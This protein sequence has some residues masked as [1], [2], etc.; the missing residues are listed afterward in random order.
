MKVLI[1]DDE[2]L[3]LKSLEHFFKSEGYET[4]LARDGEEAVEKLNQ[5]DY[6]V[7]CTDLIMPY[8]SGIEVLKESKLISKERPVL[9]LT[10]IEDVEYQDLAEAHGVDAYINKPLNPESLKF[11]LKTYMTK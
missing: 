10:G 5:S 2:S 7:I 3:M 6:D 8:K 4:V 9:I 11:W 1:A